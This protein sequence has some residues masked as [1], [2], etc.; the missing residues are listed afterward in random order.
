MMNALKWPVLA[1]ALLG[2]TACAGNVQTG[3]PA[4]DA[5][6]VGSNWSALQNLRPPADR[7]EV[8]MEMPDQLYDGD[9]LQVRV[10]SSR[11]GRLW[12][13]QVDSEDRA[14]VLFPNRP[15]Q[16]REVPGGRW[17]TVPPVHG[18][19][20]LYAAAPYGPSLLAAVVT[21]PGTDISEVLWELQRGNQPFAEAVRQV[22]GQPSWGIARRVVEVV[23]PVVQ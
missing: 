12:L 22:S 21:A 2:L 6:Q 9:L 17:V 8:L 15:G 16:Y 11:Y 18:G 13:L 14:S 10:R 23:D 5:N 4:P 7:F 1:L 3:E 19:F 20:E